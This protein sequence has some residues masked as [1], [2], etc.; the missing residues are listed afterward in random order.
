MT[1]ERPNPALGLKSADKLK[2]GSV[3]ADFGFASEEAGNA[4]LEITAAN[5]NTAPIDEAPRGLFAQIIN[6]IF[7]GN[8]S[9]DNNA[10]QAAISY[11]DKLRAYMDALGVD[12]ATAEATMLAEESAA[13]TAAANA[14]RGPHATAA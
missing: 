14:N 10:D 12:E 8:D 4:Q 2:S 3:T 1:I 6:G 11:S 13:K 9:A 7:G 5:A